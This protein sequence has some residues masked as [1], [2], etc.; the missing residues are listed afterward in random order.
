MEKEDLL[1]KVMGFARKGNGRRLLN[2]L[3]KKDSLTSSKLDEV[4]K[5]YRDIGLPIEVEILK[6][7]R[8]ILK[9]GQ[10]NALAEKVRG[11]C[12]SERY[13]DFAVA[14][15]TLL[16]SGMTMNPTKMEI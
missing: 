10:Y 6:Q 5:V 1:D 4:L 3:N 14:L 12:C 15:G 2:T 7:R 16:K 8:G 9:D 13:D 11:N